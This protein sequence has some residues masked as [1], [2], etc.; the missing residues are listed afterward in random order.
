MTHGNKSRLAQ[1]LRSHKAFKK[2]KDA[3]GKEID[4]ELEK[5]YKNLKS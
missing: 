1:I 3:T 4:H 5:L 2:E